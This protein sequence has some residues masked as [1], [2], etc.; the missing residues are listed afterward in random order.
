M[1]GF[2]RLA[3]LKRVA[4]VLL[5]LVQGGFVFQGCNEASVPTNA[6]AKGDVIVHQGDAQGTT[7]LIK[8]H[9][10]SAVPQAAVD[11]VLE[12]VD[13]EFN[14]W[15]PESRINMLNSFSDKDSLFKFVD[16]HFLWSS[17][18]AQSM[19]LFE[20]SQ[21][22]FDP[23]VQPLVE[24]WG[25]GLSK[26]GEVTA[27]AVDSA[28]NHIGMTFENID[29]NEVERDR[30]YQFTTVRKRNP[31]TRLDFNGIAQGMTVDLLVEMLEENGVKN[32]MVEVGGEVR[33]GGVRLDGTP[34]RIAVDQPIVAS[35]GEYEREMQ[36]VMNVSDAA[37]CN[38]W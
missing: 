22:A 10:A 33:C 37:I 15:R 21:G 14:L 25:F 36:T 11:S 38:Q 17:I 7:Y 16:E 26:R 28:L 30:I 20:A 24:L 4:L 31:D 8:Y 27:E 34:W 9:G 5:V 35:E 19:D 29:L 12:V 6:D 18:W 13:I 23:T 1:Q 3:R 2:L 32:F